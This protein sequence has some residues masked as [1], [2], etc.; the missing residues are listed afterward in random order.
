MNLAEIRQAVRD[1]LDLPEEDDIATALIDL[2]IAEGFQNV[3][4]REARWP[5]Y[6]TEWTDTTVAGTPTIS[7]PATLSSIDHII[8]D[9]YILEHINH[10]D[11]E[12]WLG[13]DGQGTPEMFSI[14]GDKIYLWPTPNAAEVITIR[15]WRISSDDWLGSAA[16][17]PDTGTERRLDRALVHYACSRAY[18]QQEDPELQEVYRVSFERLVADA[19]QA[20]MRPRYHGQVIMGKGLPRRRH[21]RYTWM[22]D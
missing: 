11:A 7:V 14:W 22:V 13:R 15:G 4:N 19:Q 20:I 12:E 21:R 9:G 17:T 18:A 5:F 10:E 16:N 2:Y 6:A 8:R 3:I 1:Q